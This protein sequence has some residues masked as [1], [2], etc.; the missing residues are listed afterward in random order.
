MTNETFEEHPEKIVIPE[1]QA[2]LNFM[3]DVFLR[4]LFKSFVLNIAVQST[5]VFRYVGFLLHETF[6]TASLQNSEE[7]CIPYIS[8]HVLS[9][10]RHGDRHNGEA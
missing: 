2:Y 1:F 7:R 4:I 8:Q 10:R 3:C 5:K 6:Q 9:A